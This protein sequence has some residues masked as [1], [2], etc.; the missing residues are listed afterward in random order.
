LC[1]STKINII[2]IAALDPN[3]K[4]LHY[5]SLYNKGNYQP[6]DDRLKAYCTRCKGRVKV[7]L[8]PSIRRG[9]I[10]GLYNRG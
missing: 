6:Y 8:R 5:T 1:Y 9:Y 4:S 2:I 7:A 3:N 10:A